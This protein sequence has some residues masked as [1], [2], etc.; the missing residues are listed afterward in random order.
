MNILIWILI[1]TI[2][3]SLGSLLGIITLLIK[4]KILE[5]I[6]LALVSLSAGALI[7]GAFLHL[8]PESLNQM[9]DLEV[10]IIVIL[11]FSAFFLIEKFLHWRHCH[12]KKC[13][14]HTFTYMNLFGDGIHNFIDGLIISAAF[15]TS[16]QIGIV[17]T[18]AVALHE[19]P[20]EIG[21]FGVLVYGGIKKM[22]ALFLNF[23]CALTAVF[24]G[25]FGYFLSS[26][27]KISLTFL[28]PFAAGGFIYIAASDLIPE[29]RKEPSLKKSLINFLI[30]IF[31]ILILYLMKMIGF[32]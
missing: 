10:S 11:G 6:L 9:E 24:G 28:L 21:D 14:I 8:I 13:A 19:I 32:E 4:D 26:Y 5:K 1:S 27:S 16:I 18:I 7:G 29:I 12:T 30:F 15:F 23:I 22:R 20:Q 17:T 25:I 3:V 2:L 31:G